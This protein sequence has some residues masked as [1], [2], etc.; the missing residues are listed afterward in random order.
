ME[1]KERKYGMQVAGLFFV[2]LVLA[3]FMYFAFQQPAITGAVTYSNEE[4]NLLT[5]F[6]FNLGMLV[7]GVMGAVFVMFL[8]TK[9][10]GKD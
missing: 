3:F 10:S 1:D 8:I 6:G 2:V 7:I 9:E 4:A 5:P